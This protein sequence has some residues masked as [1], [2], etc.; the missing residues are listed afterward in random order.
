MMPAKTPLIVINRLIAA[1]RERNLES[2]VA[3]YAQD[4]ILAVQPGSLVQGTASIRSFFEGLFRT[5]PENR[6]ELKDFI[7][8]GD[9]ALFTAKWTILSP[10]LPN[11]PLPTTNHQAII[12]RKQPDGNWL[13]I[14]D[15][16]WGAAEPLK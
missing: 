10:P 2:M 4:A 7:E 15:N 6:Y 5:N 12:L 9:L 8:A 3:L 1:I 13:I 14:V 11:V 16:P